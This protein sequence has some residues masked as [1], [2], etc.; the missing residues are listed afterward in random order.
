MVTVVTPA[1]QP[2][3]LSTMGYQL[4]EY[5]INLIKLSVITYHI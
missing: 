3:V 5:D 2:H 4:D 1:Y